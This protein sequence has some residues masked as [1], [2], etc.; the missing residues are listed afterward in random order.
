MKLPELKSLM[1]EHEIKGS[2]YMNKPDMIA[3]LLGRGIISEDSVKNQDAPAKRD[4][5]PR[6][7]FVRSI[8]NN[9][10]SVDIRDL[11]T[12]DITMYSSIYKASRAIGY[13]PKL[14]TSNNGK[15]WKDRYIIDIRN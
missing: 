4:I 6:Y 1:K 10:K 8:R 5:D 3:V 7:K 13:A 2:W 14:I 15:V 9:P 12:G 11:E